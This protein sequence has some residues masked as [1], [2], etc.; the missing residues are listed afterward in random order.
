[1]VGPAEEILAARVGEPL[2]HAPFGG[3][4]VLWAAVSTVLAIV[5]ILITTRTLGA[6]RSMPATLSAEP[7]GFARVLYHKWYVDEVYD[8]LI[9]RPILAVS[10]GL[11]RFV[12]Q[13][14]VDG[15]VNGVGYAA[16]AFGWV[17]SRLQTGQ[18]NTYAF[19][20]V[21]GTLLLL[22]FVFL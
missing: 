18:L 6:R 5:V 1:V 12:D 10:R 13:G 17:G 15:L 19:A 2:H 7:R 21:A 4:E 9:V 3:G 11:W 16:R 14:L 8:A 20:V 22:A